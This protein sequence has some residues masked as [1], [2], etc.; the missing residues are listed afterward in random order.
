MFTTVRSAAAGSVRRDWR[1]GRHGHGGG[2]GGLEALLGGVQHG[3]WGRIDGD[4]VR[5]FVGALG[6]VTAVLLLVS[7]S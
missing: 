1:T 5:V 6:V 2:G 7:L 3:A 4:G